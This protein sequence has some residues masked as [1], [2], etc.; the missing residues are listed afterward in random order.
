[1]EQNITHIC[2][3]EQSPLGFGDSISRMI[4]SAEIQ[5]SVSEGNVWRMVVDFL[6]GSLLRQ[7][8]VEK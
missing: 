1:M 6:Q 7:L 5:G 8:S 4:H 2:Y 3:L